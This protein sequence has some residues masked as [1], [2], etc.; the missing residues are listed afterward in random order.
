MTTSAIVN[1]AINISD[2][3]RGFDIKVNDYIKIHHPTVGE[4]FDGDTNL[5]SVVT[6]LCATPT[7]LAWQ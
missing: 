6:T 2:L 3:Y 4:V 1:H 5:L 7:D